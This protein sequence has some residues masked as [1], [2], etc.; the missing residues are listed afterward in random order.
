V[1][2]E[3]ISEVPNQAG[4]RHPLSGHLDRIKDVRAVLDEWRKSRLSQTVARD[5]D[6]I[7]LAE[8]MPGLEG[9]LQALRGG[10]DAAGSADVVRDAQRFG[11]LLLCRAA[12]LRTPLREADNPQKATN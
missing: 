12:V 1:K 3:P 9:V 5:L 11:D 4:K 8:H 6:A 2:T 10:V 7:A